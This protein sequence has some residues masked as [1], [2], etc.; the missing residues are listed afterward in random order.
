M[1]VGVNDIIELTSSFACFVLI[2]ECIAVGQF[3]ICVSIF[4][5]FFYAAH[6]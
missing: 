3:G 1:L 2:S 5:I 4:H 6:F